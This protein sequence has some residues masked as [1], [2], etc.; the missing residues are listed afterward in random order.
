MKWLLCRMGGCHYIGQPKMAICL[1]QNFLCKMERQWMQWGKYDT[2]LKIA[3]KLY[4]IPNSTAT[5]ITRHASI[6][7]VFLILWWPLMPHFCLLN[8]EKWVF[9]RVHMCVCNTEFPMCGCCSKRLRS[10]DHVHGGFTT[11]LE[12]IMRCILGGKCCCLQL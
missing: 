10:P 1:W 5:L 11:F 4:E 12:V 3:D 9:S 8:I 7:V 6:K 2:V